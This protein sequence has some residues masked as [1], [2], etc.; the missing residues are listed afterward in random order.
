MKRLNITLLLCMLVSALMAGIHSYTDESVLN[1][2]TFV[3]VR[4]QETGVYSISYE[5]LK[6]WGIQPEN[7]A[8][9][10]YGG[11]MLSENFTLSHWDD[12]PAVAIYMDKGIDGVFNSGD[13]I[14]FYAQGPTSWSMDKNGKWTHIQNTYSDYGYYFVTDK[15]GLQRQISF[16]E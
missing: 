5:T 3:K 9:L 13:R 2:G 7:V 6:G 14:L 15:A 8:V 4:V 10:G 11:A 1:T 16:N 12:L